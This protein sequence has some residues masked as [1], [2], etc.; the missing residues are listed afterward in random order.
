MTSYVD[1][2]IKQRGGPSRKPLANYGLSWEPPPPKNLI[3]SLKIRRGEAV[4]RSQPCTQPCPK[5]LPPSASTPRSRAAAASLPLQTLLFTDWSKM[6]ASNSL[7]QSE[8]E[9]GG[10][11]GGKGGKQFAK[12]RG[13]MT[14]ALSCPAFWFY[15]SRVVL[16]QRRAGSSVISVV[17]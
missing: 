17:V 6:S 13:R 8:R 10:K 11:K 2:G 5:L 4:A 3:S 14:E 15:N 7:W 9:S 16:T 12:D 1:L